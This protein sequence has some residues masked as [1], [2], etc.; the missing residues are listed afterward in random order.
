LSVRD[1]KAI[2]DTMKHRIVGIVGRA[3]RLVTNREALDWGYQ[4]C[5]AVFP[6]TRAGEGHVKATDPPA[7]G[8]HC[9]IDLVHQSSRLNFEFVPTQGRPEPFAPFIRLT[10][11]YDGLRASHRRKG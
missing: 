7:S 1:K 2:V 10:N 6:D 3:Y 11:S 9:F 8:Q 4:C 5:E